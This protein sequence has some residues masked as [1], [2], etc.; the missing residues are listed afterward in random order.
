MISF[1]SEHLRLIWSMVETHS[2]MLKDLSD[3]AI[4]F[5][6]LKKIKDTIYLSPAEMGELKTYIL[7]RRH[8]IRDIANSQNYSDNY[9]T[10]KR[11]N[12]TYHSKGVELPYD[13]AV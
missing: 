1:D 13:E 11:S 4:C 6:L 7:S 3:E 8:L 12:N 9:S 10:A 5:W 2:R